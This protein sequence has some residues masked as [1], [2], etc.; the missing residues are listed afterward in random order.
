MLEL[1]NQNLMEEKVDQVIQLLG[2]MIV[3]GVLDPS[4]ASAKQ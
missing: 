1:K 3:W 2:E 4:P